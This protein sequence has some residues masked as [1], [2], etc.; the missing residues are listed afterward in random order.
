MR[1][2]DCETGMIKESRESGYRWKFKEEP[3]IKTGFSTLTF[4]IAASG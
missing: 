4:F 2:A 1:I 3:F